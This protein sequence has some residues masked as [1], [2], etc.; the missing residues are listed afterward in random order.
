MLARN[1]THGA[2]TV[3]GCE[4]AQALETVERTVAAVGETTV[5][6]GAQHAEIPGIQPELCKTHAP[7][8]GRLNI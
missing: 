1:K 8:P 7:L 3:Q 2:E 4:T 5:A 6:C